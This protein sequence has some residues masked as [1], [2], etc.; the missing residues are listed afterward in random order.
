MILTCPSCATRYFVKDGAVP[1]AGRTVRCASCATEWRAMPEAAPIKL[2][3]AD[4]APASTPRAYRAKVQAKQQTRKAVAA[5]VVWAGLSAVF[6]AA[7][8]AAV[9][10][11]VEVVRAFPRANAAYAAVH[12]PVNPTGL[13]LE[14]V[15]GGPGLENGRQILLVSGLL[16]NV[17]AGPR[18]PAALTVSVFDKAGRRRAAQRVEAAPGEIAPGETRPFRAVFYDP[19]VDAAEFGV[20][21]ALDAPAARPRKAPAHVSTSV[22]TTVASAAP[23]EAAAPHGPVA[24][25][26][27][28]PTGSPYAL[29][30]GEAHP[31]P[32]AAPPASSPPPVAH[33]AAQPPAHPA[34]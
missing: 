20:D 13:G 15:T 11:R 26:A 23:L 27:P 29:P 2:A 9:L 25:A 6:V 17:E 14:G 22:R 33:A 28:L 34:H 5:G 30:G 8:F 24:E 16:R 18:R 4:A 7:A 32:A 12:M 21:F 31:A 10:F 1:A 3:E 19:P